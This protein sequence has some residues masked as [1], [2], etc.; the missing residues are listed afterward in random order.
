MWLDIIIISKRL[1]GANKMK[2]LR[3]SHRMRGEHLF[4]KHLAGESRKD[5]CLYHKISDPNPHMQ[6]FLS[7]IRS[8]TAKANNLRAM[9]K[10]CGFNPDYFR[11]SRRLCDG[12]LA[13]ERGNNYLIEAKYNDG[14]LKDHQI[15]SQ[16]KIN[17]TNGSYFIIR[18]VSK[19]KR[20]NHISFINIEQPE[21]VILKKVEKPLDVIKYFKKL[22]R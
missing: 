20:G 10:E 17:K 6:K 11:E 9:I 19:I 4:E 5:G 14:K 22:K 12:I 15:I 2:A 21:G 16:N 7:F 13:I 18:K 1:M 8:G 3:T